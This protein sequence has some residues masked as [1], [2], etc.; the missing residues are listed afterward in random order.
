M[1]LREAGKKTVLEDAGLQTYWIGF[2]GWD[3]TEL[4]ADG[5]DDLEELWESLCPEFEC[6]KDGVDYVEWAGRYIP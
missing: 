4:T 1:T 3:E 6:E 2:H 5:M